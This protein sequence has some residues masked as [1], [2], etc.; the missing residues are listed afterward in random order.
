MKSF[1]SN[2]TVYHRC[3]RDNWM[4]IKKLDE[5]TWMSDDDNDDETCL[6]GGNSGLR[7]P[8]NTPSFTSFTT[9]NTHNNSNTHY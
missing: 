1:R 2:N 3:G 8:H 4:S 5:E 6:G 7:S 9:D